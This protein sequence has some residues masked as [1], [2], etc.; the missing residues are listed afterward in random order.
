MKFFQK[1]LLS[2]FFITFVSVNF[3]Q[4]TLPIYSDYLSDNVYL[5]HPSAAGIGNC[6]K[7]RF[8]ARQ[9]WIGVPNAPA[10]QTLSF[11]S[12]LGEDSNAAYG[13]ILFNDKNGYHSQRGVQGTYTYHLPLSE[14][15]YFNQ[16]SFGL[17]FV[18]IQNQVDQRTFI[19]PLEPNINPIIESVNYFNADFSMAYHLAGFS[20][21]FTVKNLLPSKTR[22]EEETINSRNYL[23]SLGYYYGESKFIEL[24]PSLLFQYKENTGEAIADIN[25]KA[26]KTF[27]G[28]RIWAALSYRRSLDTAPVEN[29]QYFSPIFG[30]NYKNLMVSYTYT[31][32]L[33]DV[34]ISDAGLHQIS[35]GF[36][37]LCKQ[38]RASACPNINAAFEGF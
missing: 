32:Q 12:K 14:G 33:N 35:L 27:N 30:V 9:Q 15:R 23:L 31:K 2:I 10:L 18:A 11:H 5:V 26:Y 8:T 36:N 3:A 19:D 6:A 38:A 24:E 16:L 34:L 20:S 1:V 21:Y 25:I 4:E 7:A 17:S 37:L 13:F 22:L 29:L 28:T